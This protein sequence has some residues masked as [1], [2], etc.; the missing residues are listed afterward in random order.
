MNEGGAA[1]GGG[2][3]A[4]CEVGEEEGAAGRVSVLGKR[5]NRPVGST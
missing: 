1:N 2:K 4:S 5:V 3:R